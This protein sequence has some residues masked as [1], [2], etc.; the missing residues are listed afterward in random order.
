M[1]THSRSADL[2]PFSIPTVAPV[3]SLTLPVRVLTTSNTSSRVF[4]V[5]SNL[6]PTNHDRR[7]PPSVGKRSSI[8]NF[9]STRNVTAALRPKP[10][11]ERYRI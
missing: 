7:I 2:R 11:S 4:Y 3:V 10:P 6:R 1:A 5:N 9:C 8:S